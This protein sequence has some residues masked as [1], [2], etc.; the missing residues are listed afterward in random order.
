MNKKRKLFLF[1]PHPSALIPVVVVLL[2]GVVY[3]NIHVLVA[4]LQRG[5]GWSMGNYLDALSQ[6]AVLEAIATSV[7]ISIL[8]VLLC[9]VVGVPLAFLFERYT[10]PARGVFATL[11][12]LPLVLPPL[13]GTVAFIFL[14]GESG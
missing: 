12:A 3:P 7:G 1:I 5:G 13:V 6:G 11:A 9:A 4:S 10:F 2:Y 14:C 8:T